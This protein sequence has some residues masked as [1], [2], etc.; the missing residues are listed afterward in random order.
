M[1]ICIP[2]SRERL[3]VFE[4]KSVEGRAELDLTVENF[5]HVY[6]TFPKLEVDNIGIAADGP[7]ARRNKHALNGAYYRYGWWFPMLLYSIDLYSSPSAVCPV[8]HQKVEFSVESATWRIDSSTDAPLL[9]PIFPS[10]W[11]PET[12][13]APHR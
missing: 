10:R 6:C 2:K 1:D 3:V 4:E 13:Y 8:V 12:P 5:S 9:H 11:S 7:S